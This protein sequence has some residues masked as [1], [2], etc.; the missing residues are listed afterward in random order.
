MTNFSCTACSQAFYRSSVGYSCITR[1]IQ[2]TQCDKYDLNTDVCNSC[3]GGY[4]L[5]TNKKGC[6]IYPSGEPGCVSWVYENNARAC[7]A[8]DTTNYFMTAG[9][10]TKAEF[11]DSNCAVVVN[12]NSC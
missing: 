1:E 3:G 9:V 10:C 2:P 7:K 6:T 4:F 5:N 11:T 12:N 8:C